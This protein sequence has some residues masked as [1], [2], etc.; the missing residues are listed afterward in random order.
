MNSLV[1]DEKHDLF[2]HENRIYIT[3]N[4]TKHR[5]SFSGL[6]ILDTG[7]EI[8]S[9]FTEA[10]IVLS[11]EDRTAIEKISPIFSKYEVHLEQ[12]NVGQ[13]IFYERDMIVKNFSRQSILVD[14]VEHQILGVIGAD[15]LFQNNF[16]FS[17][18]DKYFAWVDELN[19]NDY[20]KIPLSKKREYYYYIEQLPYTLDNEII[21]DDMDLGYY[22][23][24]GF[25]GGL[26]YF[27][28]SQNFKKEFMG[29]IDADASIF[30][31][32][33]LYGINFANGSLSVSLVIFLP[34]NL[35]GMEIIPYFDFYYSFAENNGIL[36]LKNAY[37]KTF[38]D[39]N[40]ERS[41]LIWNSEYLNL[42]TK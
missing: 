20:I 19:V 11:P 33:N 18:H 41:S 40:D 5:K 31:Q 27:T 3:A 36:Y 13:S 25:T 39:L 22:F 8:S 15:I 12:I 23:D 35:I 28:C 10:A 16:F 30:D 21:N 17:C 42:I 26:N 7:M 32:V 4:V 29:A 1:L 34:H 14:N 9:I 37:N 6:F 24:T 2:I 38:V